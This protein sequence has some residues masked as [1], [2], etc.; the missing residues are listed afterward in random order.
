MTNETAQIKLPGH[1]YPGAN[2]DEIAA[3]MANELIAQL[4]R[5]YKD[6]K[7][8]R[9]I[10]TKMHGCVKAVFTVEPDLP[11]NLRVGIF[12]ETKS[13]HAWV[14][15]SNASTNPKPDRKKDVRGFAI[16]LMGVPGEKILNDQYRQQTQDFLLMNTETFFSKNVEDFR[17]LLKAAT[18]ASKLKMVGYALNPAHW[19]TLKRFSRSNMACNNPLEMRYWSTQPYQFGKS[20]TAVKY[21]LLPSVYNKIVIENKSDYDYLRINLAQTLYNN[22]AKF[23]FLVQFQTDTETMPIEDPTVPWKSPFFKV[24]TLTIPP[25]SFD[26]KV[27]MEFGDSLSFKSWHSLPAHRPLG[28]FNRVRRRIYETLSKYRHDKNEKPVFEPRDSDDFLDD[29]F[30]V[31]PDD[32]LASIPTKKIIKRSPSVLINAERETVFK[33]ISNS[34]ELSAW[35]T[36]F[37]MISNEKNVKIIKGPYSMPGAKRE[38]L[39]EN[40]DHV[41]EELLSFHPYANYSYR[42]TKYSNFLKKLTNGGYVTMWFDRVGDQT[43]AT[44]DYGFTYKNFFGKIVLSLFFV[45]FKKYMQHSLNNAKVQIENGDV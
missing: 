27:Q 28:S 12:K 29:T 22:E 14:R 5:L 7:M 25:Q 4:D 32:T 23:D 44:W 30:P 26:S 42:A 40:G 24:A 6:K 2:E 13:F 34:D 36:K 17:S 31:K 1:E 8:F 39:F 15:M 37:G 41:E 35:L 9:Q 45:M 38:V 19:A 20:E 10:H 21:S 33:F 18:S 11:E 16:K 43:R 3:E